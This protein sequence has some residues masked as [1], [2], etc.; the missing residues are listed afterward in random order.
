MRIKSKI[1]NKNYK[2][3]TK[4]F[5]L[6]IGGQRRNSGHF[7]LLGIGGN[8]GD[9]IRRFE[10]LLHYLNKS[11]FIKPIETSIII[12]NPPFGYIEQADFFNAIISIYTRL[13]P[14]ELL[15]YTQNVERTFGRKRSF[16]N[17]SRT[18]DID[19]ILYGKRKINTNNLVIPHPHWYKRKSVLIPLK[20][21]KGYR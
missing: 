4:L 13:S 6:R 2:I 15:R 7:V 14:E 3:S 5:P 12:K 17:A 11:P 18:L 21:M 1:D 16:K 10:H 19:I 9:T 20:S 8:I